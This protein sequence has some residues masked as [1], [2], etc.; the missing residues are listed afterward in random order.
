MIRYILVAICLLVLI[1]LWA[2]LA[3]PWLS[4]GPVIGEK[5][6]GLR[7]V[8]SYLLVWIPY[9]AFSRR[10][11]ASRFVNLTITTGSLALCWGLLEFVALVGLVD[12]RLLILSPGGGYGEMKPWENPWNRVDP[13]LIHIHRPGQRMTG[14]TAGD[15]VGTFGVPQRRS[16]PVDVQYDSRGFRNPEEINRASVVVI[17]DSFVEAGLVPERELISSRLGAREGVKVANLGQSGWGPQQELIAL[18]RYGLQLKPKIVLWFFF[19]G[20][21]LLDANRYQR[22]VQ[23]W[24]AAMKENHGFL[25]R[26]FSKNLLRALKARLQRKRGDSEEGHRRSG[27]FRLHPEEPIYFAF[28]G[29]PLSR[30][31]E[32]GLAKT[33]QILAEANRATHAGGAKFL[34]V[35]IPIKFRVYRDF[36]DFPE[37]GYGRSWKPNDLPDR[38]QRWSG[39]QGIEYLD[40]TEPLKRAAAGGGWVFFPDDGHWNGQG[41]QVG[42]EAVAAL[43]EKNG[44]LERSANY[45]ANYTNK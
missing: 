41:N 39:E 28:P 2:P 6:L 17:G 27:R 21:D 35:F 13:E 38:L 4:V 16:Y 26:S 19:E 32:Q 18:K 14:K 1:G 10:P 43:I 15:L 31:D 30:E 42:A 44:W 12:Y 24:D 5:Q 22:W 3:Q 45:A 33:K 11:R 23:N 25:T 40:L 9:L 37:G 36:C 7:L 20:N 8:A 34:L 29:V